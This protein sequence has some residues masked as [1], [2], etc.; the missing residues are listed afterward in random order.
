MGCIHTV[1]RHFVVYGLHQGCRSRPE[2]GFLGGA[3][4]A[5]SQ[6]FWV[7][8]EPPGA[9]VLEWCRIRLEPGFMGG[10]RAA[11]S[12]GF[13]VVP[14]PPRARVFGWCRSRIFC[15]APAPTSSYSY[16][17]CTVKPVILR[18]PKVILTFIVFRLF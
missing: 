6:G 17:T 3:G 8:P 4:A 5:R 14:E 10:V 1:Y 13:W 2:P 16:S 18:E 9:R 11:R 15:P 12:Q 7:V